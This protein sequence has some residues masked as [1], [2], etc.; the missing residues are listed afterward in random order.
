MTE[1]TLN[2]TPNTPFINTYKMILFVAYSSL[3]R[4]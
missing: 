3:E 1:I 4:Y 2:N